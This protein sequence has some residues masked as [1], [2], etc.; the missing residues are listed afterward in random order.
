[1]RTECLLAHLV[2]AT[3]L[4]QPPAAQP[5]AAQARRRR[6]RCNAKILRADAVASN[7]T[8][9]LQ[10]CIAALTGCRK[11][12]VCASDALSASRDSKNTSVP[13]PAV[14]S[15]VV[16]TGADVAGVSPFRSGPIRAVLQCALSILSATVGSAR[17]GV[18][19][20][21]RTEP[22]ANVLR[23]ELRWPLSNASPL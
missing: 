19:R 3:D 10:Q 15:D 21:T 1:M 2:S 18:S 20:L 8:I 16:P 14:R 12:E 11:F 7:S 17:C 5:P 9:A 6:M 22:K 13:R 4:A 23:A